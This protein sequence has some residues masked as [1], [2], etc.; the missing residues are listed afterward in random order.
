M[1]VTKKHREI[2]FYVGGLIAAATAFVGIREISHQY[3]TLAAAVAAIILIWWILV[4]QD[5]H[6]ECLQ[7]GR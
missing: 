1:N 5:M 7:R 3:G 2:A 6:T 4:V